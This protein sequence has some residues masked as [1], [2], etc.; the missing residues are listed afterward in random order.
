MQ[1]NNIWVFLFKYLQDWF[2][3]SSNFG[4]VDNEFQKS[5]D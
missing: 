4:D 2:S 5:G 3:F 1:E